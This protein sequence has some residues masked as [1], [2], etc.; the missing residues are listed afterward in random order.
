MTGFELKPHI[1]FGK[2]WSGHRIMER[3]DGQALLYIHHHPL[4]DGFAPALEMLR[5]HG[6]ASHVAQR[7]FAMPDHAVLCAAA[8]RAS[9]LRIRVRAF[10]TSSGAGN[11]RA[12]GRRHRL[13]RQPY[14]D[15]WRGS[16]DDG[17]SANAGPR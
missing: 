5:Q 7:T 2:I 9:T 6:I 3:E 15:P 16:Y 17:T 14:L 11:A 13:R 12:A 4:Q 1:L 8:L 10:C